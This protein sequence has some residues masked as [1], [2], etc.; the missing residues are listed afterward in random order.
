MSNGSEVLIYLSFL[1]KE[2]FFQLLLQTVEE[3]LPHPRIRNGVKVI[4]YSFT[5]SWV[6][7]THEDN[8]DFSN[9]TFA[10]KLAYFITFFGE[11]KCAKVCIVKFGPF[12]YEI[13]NLKLMVPT[14]L[15]SVPTG[16]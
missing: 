11:K 10:N 9:P 2:A 7:A 16:L 12:F 3:K 5:V 4:Q 6:R 15:K 8:W 14:D 13:D 1:L